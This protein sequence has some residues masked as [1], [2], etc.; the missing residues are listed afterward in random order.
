SNA[1]GCPRGSKADISAMREPCPLC[2]QDRTFAL[3]KGMSAWANSGHTVDYSITSSARSISVLGT[4]RPNAF[5]V[6]RLIVTSRSATRT[7]ASG[8]RGFTRRS[9]LA[10]RGFEQRGSVDRGSVKWRRARRDRE[11]K[12]GRDAETQQQCA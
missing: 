3:Q 10:Q 7:N 8:P 6:L 4:V 11:K 9:I 2:P 1:K 5:A 12:G